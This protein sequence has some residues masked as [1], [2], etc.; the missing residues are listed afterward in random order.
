MRFLVACLAALALAVPEDGGEAARGEARPRRRVADER[1]RRLL[2][3]A[4]PTH[5]SS[6]AAHPVGANRKFQTADMKAL[7]VGESRPGADARTL[8]VLLG[9]ARGGENT[10][11]T[12]Y[13]RVLDPNGADLALLL[14]ARSQKEGIS[15]YDRAKYIWEVEDFKD[16][17]DALDGMGGDGSWRSIAANNNESFEMVFGGAG[18]TPTGN[19]VIVPYLKWVL[20]GKI[21]EYRLLEAYDRF[22]VTRTDQFYTCNVDLALYD[23][24]YVWVPDAQDYGGICDRWIVAPSSL[25]MRTLDIIRPVVIAPEKYATFKGNPEALVK[26]RFQ[27]EGV[28]DAIRRFGRHMFT[29]ATPGDHTRWKRIVGCVFN[30]YNVCLKYKEEFDDAM[31]GCGIRQIPAF[32]QRCRGDCRCAEPGGCGNKVLRKDETRLKIANAPLRD[33]PPPP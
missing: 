10:W 11:R 31:K 4:P 30:P 19:G 7:R 9:N 26:L 22:V 24:K 2:V 16:W 21:R 23:P 15:L 12:L 27:E 33:R 5:N 29:A 6:T 25:V 3:E 18:P 14:G 32:E 17:S 20:M 28:W 13:D 1:G 8:V